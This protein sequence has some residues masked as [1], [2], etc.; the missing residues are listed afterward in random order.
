VFASLRRKSHSQLAK[1]EWNEGLGH[2][3]HA[4]THAAKGLETSVR[5]QFDAARRQ[6]APAASKVRSSAATGWASTLATVAPLA[7]AASAGTG[8]ALEKVKGKNLPM[9]R[10]QKKQ[11]ARRRALTTGMLAAGAVAGVA[12]A[13]ALRR[14]REQQLMWEAYEPA[15][16]SGPH[17]DVETVVVA[18]SNEPAVTLET[19]EEADRGVGA[20]ALRNGRL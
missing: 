18:T 4:A 6:V 2:L 11:K 10:K 9:A 17:D 15:E 20:S 19:A 14:R 7:A 12:G 8:T 16:T 1:V 3:R 5:P 13:L